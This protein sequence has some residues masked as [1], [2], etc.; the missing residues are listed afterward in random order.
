MKLRLPMKEPQ[1]LPRTT[2]SSSS[3]RLPKK[4]HSFTIHKWNISILAREVYKVSNIY[5]QVFW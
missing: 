4:K 3:D 2:D 1:A 5:V